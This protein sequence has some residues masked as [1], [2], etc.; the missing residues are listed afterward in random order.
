MSYQF[1]LEK[2]KKKRISFLGHQRIWGIL[3]NNIV[4][5][6][7]NILYFC[8]TMKQ[9]CTMVTKHSLKGSYSG[10]ASM[11]VKAIQPL[12]RTKNQK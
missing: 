11:V 12:K 9:T 7:N 2:K 6:G 3:Q 10:K 5:L 1:P 4:L 8:T